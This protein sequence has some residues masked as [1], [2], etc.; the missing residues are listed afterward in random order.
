MVLS[1][2]KQVMK[3]KGYGFCAVILL[4]LPI[5]FYGCSN[6]PRD[7]RRD[8]LHSSLP[9]E[10]IGER[11]YQA[12]EA[13]ETMPQISRLHPEAT[14]LDGYAVQQAFVKHMREDHG[15]GGYKAAVV[16]ASAQKDFGINGP[17]TAVLPAFGVRKAK[18][19]MV[20]DLS[21]YPGRKVETEIG[22]RFHAS[23]DEPVNNVEALREKVTAVFSVIEVPGGDLEEVNPPTAADIAAWNGEARVI[24]TGA[25]HDPDEVVPDEVEITLRHNGQ[26]INQTRGGVAAGG[27]Y[28]TL[29][30]TVNNLVSRGYTISPDQ[31]IT[32]GA[33]GNILPLK[34]GTYSAEF[35]SLGDT[36]FK[37][38]NDE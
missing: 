22:Y 14:L 28:A 18:Q 26:V 13:G 12:W 25:E 16:G 5:V 3:T 4:V 23:I 38:I 7:N 2:R 29:L 15:I 9:Y 10:A 6:Q 11:M 36:E 34:T 33:L 32:N 19:N 35:S 21:E 31:S 24:V 8:G 17:I 37:V 20:I 1:T 27:Q 30:K